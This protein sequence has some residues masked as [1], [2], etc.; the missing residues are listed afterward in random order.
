MRKMA[1]TLL[2]AMALASAVE[3]QELTAALSR[4]GSLGVN[5]LD[6]ELPLSV[7]LRFTLPMS[8]RFA[9]EPFVTAG[10]QPGRRRAA[11]EG[12]YGAQIRQRFVRFTTQNTY[13]FATYGVAAYYSRSG[14]YPPVIGHFGFGLHQEISKHVSFRP[15]VQLVSFHVVP[16][17]VRFVAGLSLDWEP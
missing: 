3:A 6:G 1:P 13:V 17:G 11:P 2:F 15:E 12:F 4:Y 8:D 14:S 16:I 10:S 7:E 9:L 5:D